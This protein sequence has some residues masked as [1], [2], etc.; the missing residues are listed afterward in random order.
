MFASEV[1]RRSLMN[2]GRIDFRID[3]SVGD[4]RRSRRGEV[5]MTGRVNLPHPEGGSRAMWCQSMLKLRYDQNV[6]E[7]TVTSHTAP[8]LQFTAKH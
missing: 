8:N 5:M 7:V 6:R 3:T 1:S 4:V 2:D